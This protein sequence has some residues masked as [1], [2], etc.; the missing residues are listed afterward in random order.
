MQQAS[1]QDPHQQAV[2]KATLQPP[3]KLTAAAS[4]RN[5]KTVSGTNK[6]LCPATLTT[7]QVLQ[8]NKT[9][10]HHTP[11]LLFVTCCHVP[12]NTSTRTADGLATAFSTPPATTRN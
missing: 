4:Q 6:Q 8:H 11:Q 9:L 5:Q 7:L 12:T 3:N 2:S 10:Q 1:N